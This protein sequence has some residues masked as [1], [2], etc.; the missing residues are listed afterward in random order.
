MVFRPDKETDMTSVD[1]DRELKTK[2][3]ALW[4]SGDYAAVAAELIPELGPALVQA[5]R[6]TGGRPHSGRRRGLGERVHPGR[7]GRGDRH[8]E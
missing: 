2:H 3:R 5:V 8:G 7:R 1:V 4:A 6:R